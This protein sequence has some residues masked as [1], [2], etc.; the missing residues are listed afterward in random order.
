MENLPSHEIV[1]I[2]A[3]YAH[4]HVI[5]MWR[6]Q[7]IPDCRLTL[8]SPEPVCAYSAM[9][10]GA[11]VGAYSPD[12]TL[13][14]LEWLTCSAGVRLILSDVSGLDPES[15]YVLL[16]DR[17]PLRY[18]ILSIAVGSVPA[19]L[20]ANRGP[21]FVST[22]PLNSLQERLTARLNELV[23]RTANIVIVGGGA[24]GVELTFCVT[25]RLTDR[26]QAAN[27]SL[28]ESGS[29]V[30]GEHRA[31]TARLAATLLTERGVQV[32]CNRNVVINAAGRLVVDETAEIPADLILWCVGAAPQKLLAMLPLPKSAEGFLLVDRTLR[33]VSGA[34]IF[35]AGDTCQI[36]NVD[37]PRSGVNAVRQ[38]PV[39]WKNL[40]AVVSDRSLK[41]FSPRHSVLSLISTG[42]SRAIGEFCFLSGVGHNLWKLKQY[43]DRR[44]MAMHQPDPNGH[45]MSRM[46]ERPRLSSRDR[47]AGPN[48]PDAA[49]VMRCS[50]CGG[51]T[52]SRVLRDVLN[53]LREENPKQAH[54]AF[55]QSE[56]A[57]VF[58]TSPGPVDAASSDFFPAF[59]DD[60][61]MTGRITA[62]HA[63]S[64]LWARG[65][66]PTLALAM[67]T[68]PEGSVRQQSE[69]LYQ[70]LSGGLRELSDAETILAGGHTTN[71]TELT[72]GFT[73]LGQ[74]RGLPPFSK[75][76][77]RPGQRIILT[78]ALGVGVILAAR[79]LGHTRAA[80]FASVIWQMLCGN[81]AASEIARNFGV[82]GITDI[83]GFG[84][85]GHLIEMLEASDFAAEL[86]LSSLPLIKG[87]A[88]LFEAGYRSSLDPENRSTES[89][90]RLHSERLN[91]TAA[92]HAL[93]DPQTSGGL[94]I[95]VDARTEAEFLNQLRNAG[96][97]DAAAIG[98]VIPK[99]IGESRIIVN[100]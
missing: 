71:G 79:S 75:G 17:P 10:P 89:A 51:K 39:L 95:A 85:A 57:A 9:L 58:T 56:D 28:Y 45:T 7:P 1:L 12:E 74:T 61:W 72:V 64:D 46:T 4:L 55:L 8:I 32:H 52:S 69:L 13:I 30:L 49:S 18:D 42:D 62:I 77:L 31:K 25:Q 33:C 73:I 96:Y 48:G 92:W 93:F 3:G 67:V 21:E 27:V 15:G 29:R 40:N 68:L 84:L 97:A 37:A 41:T 99:Q 11:V 65:I 19:D 23:D 54:P 88:E 44:F 38:G 16:P 86:S 36:Q 34:P 26:G 43:I 35:A 94:L 70:L 2:G 5:R 81:R 14:D 53:R 50:G 76:G 87:A 47:R 63:L 80:T 83:T 22:K 90:I 78:K 20:P 91:T 82:S 60:P 6:T 98:T 24:V 100:A 66:Q 59:L